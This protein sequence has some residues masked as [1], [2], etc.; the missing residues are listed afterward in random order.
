MLYWPI[1]LAVNP[2]DNSL[3]ILDDN[4]V[5]KITRE[6]WVQKVAGVLVHCYHKD[7]AENENKKSNREMYYH[8]KHRHNNQAAGDRFYSH[9]YHY[10]LRKESAGLKDAPTDEKESDEVQLNHAYHISFSPNGVLHVIENNG[11][12]INR[13]ISIDSQGRRT[14]VAGLHQQS[15]DCGMGHKNC[16]CFRSRVSKATSSPLNS[17]SSATFTPDGVLYIADTSNQRIRSVALRPREVDE[18]DQIS[19]VDGDYTYLFNRFGHH[20]STEAT[21]SGKSLYNFTHSNQMSV[22]LESITDHLG[23]TLE[24]RQGYG[25]SYKMVLNKKSTSWLVMNPMGQIEVVFPI[26]YSWI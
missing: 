19:V 12:D 25:Q 26:D 20:V 9:Y 7:G 10:E 22:S 23:N 24:I 4:V 5:F 6:G 1:S 13:V 18:A 21:W 14:L 16:E 17:P 11:K 15:C 2:L 3:H 8:H